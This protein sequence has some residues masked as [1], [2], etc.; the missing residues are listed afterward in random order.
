MSRSWGRVPRTQEEA[1]PLAF[2]TDALPLPRDGRTSLAHGL[3]RSYGDS[4]LNDGGVLLETPR[5]DHVLGFDEATG[6]LRVEAGVS[7]KEILRL[8][9]PR[10]WFLPVT[11][12]TKLVTVGGAIA[13]DVHGKNHH[14]A[15][16]FGRHVTRFELA[17]SDG[18]R[19]ICSPTEN[20]EWFRATIGGLGLTGLVTWAEIRLQRIASPWIEAEN[21]RMASLEDFFALSRASART[22]DYT[23]AWI[24]STAKGKALGR[25]HFTQGNFAKASPR[26]ARFPKDERIPVPVDMPEMAM[27][28]L[29][30]RAFNALYARK[31]LRARKSGL[32]HWDPFFYPLDA[33]AHWNRGFGK[34][35]VFQYQCVL[36]FEDGHEALVEMME[37]SARARQASFL[38]V[39]KTFGD[40]PSPGLLSFPKPGVTLAIDY[41]NRGP[42]TLALLDE[43]DAITR[44]AGGRVYPAKD[45][46]MSAA[47]FQAY[48]PQWSELEKY[49]DPAF[50]SSFWRR[51]TQ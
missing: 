33:I 6:L 50:S 40:L 11:P 23:V 30:V 1:R 38:T 16:T 29:P 46:R 5:M 9:V 17:R 51:V 24:D 27:G 8:F 12:G 47:S 39:L 18:T 44:R 45:A 36:P 34:R 22:H 13:N 25:G 3:G 26:E 19:M 35:G 15:G 41:P 43:L 20:A 49:R 10:G 14:V 48:Y 28:P 42:R 7:L 4:C 2:A 32:M 31:Q 37:L 21:I